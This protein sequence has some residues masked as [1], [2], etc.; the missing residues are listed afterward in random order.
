[1]SLCTVAIVGKESGVGVVPLLVHGGKLALEDFH[2]VVGVTFWEVYV[3]VE[4]AFLYL[5]GGGDACQVLIVYEISRLVC[6]CKGKDEWGLEVEAFVGV[7]LVY[8]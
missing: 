6:V 8:A 1:M 5:V 2:D 3:D 4:G 7:V